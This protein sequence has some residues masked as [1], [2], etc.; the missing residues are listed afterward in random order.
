MND[1]EFEDLAPKKARVEIIPLIDVV[2]FLLATF[3]LFT[4]SL[5]KIAG[6]DAPLPSPGHPDPSA[7]DDTVYIQA[8]DGGYFWKEGRAGTHELVRADELHPRLVDYRRRVATP[9][10]FVRGDDKARFGPAI[11]V[12]DEARKAH[13]AQISIETLTS[14]TGR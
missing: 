10:V 11:L 12:F 9:R 13:I 5:N 8:T 6:I 4:L 7:A 14:V 2:F 1:S 3:V